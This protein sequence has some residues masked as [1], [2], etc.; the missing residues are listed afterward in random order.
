[1]NLSAYIFGQ[2][3]DGKTQYPL[4][5][6][7][8]IF[9]K[10]FE[11]SSG[12]DEILTHRDGDLMYYGYLRKL[13]DEKSFGICIVLNDL[14]FDAPSELFAVFGNIFSRIAMEGELIKVSDDGELTPSVQS[15]ADELRKCES[16]TSSIVSDFKRADI[17]TSKLP[18]VSFSVGIDETKWLSADEDDDELANQTCKYPYAVISRD[19]ARNTSGLN[20]YISTVRRLNNEKNSILI[21]F[22]QLSEEY[23][24]LKHTKKQM[25][26][27]AWLLVV[28]LFCGISVF[29]LVGDLSSTK[30]TLGKTQSELDNANENI[31]TL[32]SRLKNKQDSLYIFKRNYSAEMHARI[33]LENKLDSITRLVSSHFPIIITDVEVKNE[34]RD[35]TIIDYFGSTINSRNTYYITPRITYAGFIDE[36]LTLNIKFYTPKGLSTSGFSTFTYQSSFHCYKGTN[37]IELN[38][39]GSNSPGN[40]GPGRYT[41]EFWYDDYCVG[42]YSF[43]IY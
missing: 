9:E 30:D 10:F 20:D 3:P 23:T 35:G 14:M 29:F 34:R 26:L 7:D 22:K 16:L 19:E 28:L 36:D 1:M 41:F 37:T 40:W 5:Y 6:T 42:S 25:Q 15:F 18:P 4:D 12:E 24:K 11:I 13:A 8:R 27:V 33:R 39:W 43:M 17:A 32:N 21:S 31:S 2:F 38:G